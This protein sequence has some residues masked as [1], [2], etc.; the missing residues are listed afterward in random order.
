VDLQVKAIK[1]RNT[2]PFMIRQPTIN[3][4]EM[5]VVEVKQ[6]TNTLHVLEGTVQLA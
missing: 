2:N 6:K 1:D 3:H 5:S 4:I